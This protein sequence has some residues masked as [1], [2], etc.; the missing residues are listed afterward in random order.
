VTLLFAA[1]RSSVVNPDAPYFLL[2]AI[3]NSSSTARRNEKARRHT[4]ATAKRGFPCQKTTIAMTFQTNS[5][6]NSRPHLKDQKGIWGG[7]AKDNRRFINA[8]F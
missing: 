3:V 1:R 7:N 5:E 8:V 2:D 4:K 6:K